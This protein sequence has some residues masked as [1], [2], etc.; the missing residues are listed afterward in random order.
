MMGIAFLGFRTFLGVALSIG[1]RSILI[2]IQYLLAPY[3]IASLIDSESK[4]FETWV[5]MIAGNFMINFVQIYGCYFV[6]YMIN[7]NII[8]SALGGDMVG[9]LAKIILLIAGFM[10]I[11]NIPSFVGRILGGS[12]STVGQAWNE[13]QGVGRMGLGAGSFATGAMLGSVG[14]VASMVGGG[15]AGFRSTQGAGARTLATANGLASGVARSASAISA[16]MRGRRSSAS[17][18]AGI[19]SSG[20]GGI[21]QAVRGTGGQQ[22]SQISSTGETGTPPRGGSHST[23]YSGDGELSDTQIAEAESVGMDTDG[24]NREEYDASSQAF[25]IEQGYAPAEEQVR[26]ENSN[27]ARSAGQQAY[28]AQAQQRLGSKKSQHTAGAVN[29]QIRNQRI[30][31]DAANHRKE[32]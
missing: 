31:D 11:E 16:G 2:C 26:T 23:G 27:P 24:M 30:V 8:H 5:R 19:L 15:I 6:L 1:K 4:G 18:G 10:A 14:T 7:S 25:S 13:A 29:S 32:S 12:S 3:A 9:I 17:I 22:S 20:V 21:T 28:N